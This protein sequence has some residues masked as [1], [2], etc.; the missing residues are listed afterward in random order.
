M[1][2]GRDHVEVAGRQPEELSQLKVLADPI[3]SQ[4]MLWVSET[5]LISI[6][7]GDVLSNSEGLQECE[8]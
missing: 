4:T 1:G 5:G 2:V 8:N 6:M 3:M 7:Q